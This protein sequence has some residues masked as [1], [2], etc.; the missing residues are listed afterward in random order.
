MIW[1]ITY[2]KLLS[3]RETFILSGF[4]VIQFISGM[5]ITGSYIAFSQLLFLALQFIFVARKL[6]NWF[7]PSLLISIEN[8]LILLSWIPTLDTWDI[9]HINQIITDLTY[10]KYLYLFILLQQLLLFFLILLVSYLNKRFSLSNSISL[11]PK[12]YKLLSILMLLLLLLL[13]GLKQFSVLQG[14]PISVLY[15]SGIVIGSTIIITFNLLLAIKYNDEKKYIELLSE[16]YKQEKNKVTLSEEFRQEYQTLLLSLNSYLE[17]KDKEKAISLLNG[18]I[19]YSDPLLTPNLYKKISS[20]SNPA[21]RGLLTS[22]LTKC[23]TANIDIRLNV[24]DNLTNVKMNIVDFIRCLSILLNN[25]YEATEQTNHSFI[26][27]TIEGTKDF[28][29]VEVRNTYNEEKKVSFQTLLQNNFSTKI[30]HQ[31]KGLHIFMTILDQY[32]ECDYTITQ[33]ENQFIANFTLLKAVH[34]RRHL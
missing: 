4:V 13:S 3:L 25:A 22:F 26:S 23:L 6:N 5:F 17:Q 32:P 21:V 1:L 18:I 30:G 19:D 20:I 33:K 2:K 34:E 12:K 27:I 11:L 7:I 10:S 24:T 28:L 15:S 16:A 14:D 31:G 29:T 8:S 9:L